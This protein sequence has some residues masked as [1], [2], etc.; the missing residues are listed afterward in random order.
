MATTADIR[1]GMVIDHRGRRMKIVSFLHVKPGKGGAFVRTKLKNVVS[2]QVIDITFRSGEKINPVRLDSK[3][4]QYLYAQSGS[5]VFMDLDTYE[6]VTVPGEVVGDDA[7][8]IKEGMTVVVNSVE[9]EVLDIEPPLFAEL[10]VSETEPGVRGNRATGGF[11]SAVLETG[12]RISVP[13]FV[14][15]GDVLKV[16]TRT[17]DY[18]ERVT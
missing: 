17:G 13:L 8:Y 1:N 11:K 3:K 15:E 10:Q 7:Q 2:G 4:M 6:Q 16:D 5:F 9:G 12:L 18:V 14:D